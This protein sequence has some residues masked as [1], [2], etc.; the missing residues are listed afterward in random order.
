MYLGVIL[1]YL[2]G[3]MLANSLWPVLLL[4][5]P[6]AILTQIVIPYEEASMRQAF[7]IAYEA[8]CARVRR[9]I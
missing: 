8:Y 6:L 5:G 9:W 4:A 2:G 7:G 1:I 3:C